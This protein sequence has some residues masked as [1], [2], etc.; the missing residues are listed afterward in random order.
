MTHAALYARYSSD[1]QSPET[2]QTQV[3]ACTRFC[4]AENLTIISQYTDEAVS[5]KTEQREEYQQ[6]IADATHGKFET[7]VVYRFDRLGRDFLDTVSR[8]SELR[9]AGVEVWSATEGK[10]PL[11]RNISLA[12][13]EHETRAMGERVKDALK[14]SVGQRGRAFGTAPMGYTKIPIVSDNGTK[15]GGNLIV[16]ECERSAIETIFSLFLSGMG[17]RKIAHRLNVLNIKPRKALKW[18]QYTVLQILKNP[19][20]AGVLVWN[21]TRSK[22]TATGTTYV[23]NPRDEWAWNEGQHHAYVSLA[24]WEYIQERL[25]GQATNR[26]T[27]Q[28]L[29]TGY[30]FCDCGERYFYRKTAKGHTDVYKCGQVNKGYRANCPNSPSVPAQAIENVVLKFVTQSL[31]T[32]DAIE[33]LHNRDAGATYTKERAQIE[34]A[35]QK[36]RRRIDNLTATGS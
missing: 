17:S 7:V 14:A 9:N 8:L 3:D 23:A 10:N 5:G 27:S 2:I 15:T 12:L 11:L 35:L 13:A 34:D 1:L 21:R 25:D 30:L 28:H 18:S 26:K 32:K 29:L 16:N 31:L 33:K 20:Y 6:M 22:R 36:T 4:V 24:D 19:I